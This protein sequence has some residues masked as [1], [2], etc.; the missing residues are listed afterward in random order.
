[1]W[2]VAWA[3]LN[4]VTL[5]DTLPEAFEDDVR[6]YGFETRALWD[7]DAALPDHIRRAVADY[8]DRQIDAVQQTIFPLH[9]L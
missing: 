6:R 3:V 5:P 9:Q 7:P 8:A 2:T 1:M 4:G